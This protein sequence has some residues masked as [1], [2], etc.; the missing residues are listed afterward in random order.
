MNR[1]R[2]EKISKIYQFFSILV[3]TQTKFC[4]YIFVLIYQC[5]YYNIYKC[6]IYLYL[7]C[8]EIN[9]NFL[10]TWILWKYIDFVSSGF[11]KILFSI[12]CLHWQRA[13]STGCYQYKKIDNPSFYPSFSSSYLF[14]PYLSHQDK[15][16]LLQSPVVIIYVSHLSAN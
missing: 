6:N 15:H 11:Q 8:L 1:G 3:M 7:E 4:S 9:S 5:K 2:G 16:L 10:R 14:F 13:E 12:K